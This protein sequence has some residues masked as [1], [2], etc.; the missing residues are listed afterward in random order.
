MC[1]SPLF[2]FYRT[3]SLHVQFSLFS[4]YSDSRL[5]LLLYSHSFKCP[6]VLLYI[7]LHSSFSSLVFSSH[8]SLNSFH[9][10][11]C[12]QPIEKFISRNFIYTCLY[13][14]LLQ[15]WNL[16]W[17]AISFL[18]LLSISS[19]S[20]LCFKQPSSQLAFPSSPRAFLWAS[21]LHFHFLLDLVKYHLFP[22]LPSSS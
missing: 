18:L 5:I 15:F 14:I 7:S 9:L 19:P 2:N 11:L 8:V 3:S 4:F 20:R 12:F 1:P 22:L 17:Q 21:D 10:P 6:Q 13:L 16:L